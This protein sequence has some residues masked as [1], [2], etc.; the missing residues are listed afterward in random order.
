MKC[1]RKRKSP[2]QNGKTYNV[3]SDEQTKKLNIVKVNLHKMF[4]ICQDIS[5]T[6]NIRMWIVDVG[7]IRG[8]TRLIAFECN[9][10][11]KTT[12]CVSV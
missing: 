1:T 12:R 11:Q 10:R 9:L 4:K 5:T 6:S 2:L 7:Y 3:K 8:K